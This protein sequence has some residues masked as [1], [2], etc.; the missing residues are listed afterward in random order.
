MVNEG[1]RDFVVIDLETANSDMASICQIGLVHYSNGKVASEWKTYIDPEEYFSG[2]NI[3]IHGINEETVK[4]APKFSQISSQLEEYL[5][6]RISISHTHF[7]RVA[8]QR[9]HK[10]H[11]LS[12]P[13]CIWL[14]SAKVARRT[15]HEF[16]KG[17]YGLKNICNKLGFEFGHHDALEDAK[18]AAFIMLSAIKESGIDISGWIERAAKPIG[19]RRRGSKCI[20]L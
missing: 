7:D 16:A 1:N 18:A 4:G 20:T 11:G 17:G 19:R 14:D 2:V 5:R 8:L 12:M 3:G 6:D 9:A 13:N 15:W 10:K